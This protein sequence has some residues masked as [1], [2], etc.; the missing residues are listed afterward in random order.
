MSPGWIFPPW[1]SARAGTLFLQRAS[2]VAV[3]GVIDRLAQELN[4]GVRCAI[5]PEGT[6]T[7]G[8]D[9]APFRAAL[10]GPAGNGHGVV[11]A[12]AIRYCRDGCRDAV[13]PF[14]GD[15][16]FLPHLWRILRHGGFEV[17][18]HFCAPATAA[19]DRRV[20]AETTRAAIRQHLCG[21]SAATKV[22]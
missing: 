5:F 8:D 3:R 16:A 21:A 14:V 10:Y 19:A 18:L 15:E 22:A 13:A 17:R 6:T 1:L 9:V 20:L 11:Q 7:C 12:V 4:H 2:L